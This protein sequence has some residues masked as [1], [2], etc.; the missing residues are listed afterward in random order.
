MSGFRRTALGE[1]FYGM[2]PVVRWLVA[3]NL[4]IWLVQLVTWQSWYQAVWRWLVLSDP[5]P[6]VWQ[7]VT[8]QF[9]HDPSGPMH[10]AFNMLMVWMFGRQLEQRWGWAFFLRF[11]LLCGVGAGLA[12]VLVGA[13]LPQFAGPALGASGALMGLFVGFGMTWPEARILIMFVIPMK[14]KH[15]VLLFAAVDLLMAWNPQNGVANFAHLGGMLTGYLY[16]KHGHRLRGGNPLRWL[17]GR[18]SALG[19]SRR[20]RNMSVVEEQGWDDWLKRELDEDDDDSKET[21]H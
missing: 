14:A 4:A 8:Y 19:R 6:W 18:W 17:A 7:L 1:I 20:R 15:A 5:I 10:V 3:S 21:R 11:Y 13:L 12:H 2:S 9:L 16:L